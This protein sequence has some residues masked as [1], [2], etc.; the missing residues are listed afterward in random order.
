MNPP[1]FSGKGEYEIVAQGHLDERW[2]DW[3]EGMTVTPGYSGDGT[4]ITTFAGQLIDQAALHGVIAR[5]R[6]IRMALISVNQIAM[7]T[8]GTS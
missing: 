5:I 6:D 7:D 8:N 4:P 1:G 3:F 2:S